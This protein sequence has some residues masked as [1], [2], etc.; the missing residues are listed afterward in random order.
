M[1]GKMVDAADAAAAGATSANMGRVRG[2]YLAKARIILAEMWRK[3]ID[4]MNE[5]DRTRTM[6][7]SL[8]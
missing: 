6:K 8:C 1:T 2:R 5:S 7:G 4:A 3:K